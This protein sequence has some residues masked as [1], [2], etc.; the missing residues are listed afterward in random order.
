MPF[1]RNSAVFNGYR[2]TAAELFFESKTTGL[3]NWMGMSGFRLSTSSGTRNELEP[4]DGSTALFAA[5]WFFDSGFSDRGL[6][7]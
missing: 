3:M 7:G 4:D 2:H 1:Y 5:P 6:F